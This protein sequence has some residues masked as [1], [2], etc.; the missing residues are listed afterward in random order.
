MKVAL[1]YSSK[2]GMASLWNRRRVEELREDEDEPPP[3]WFAECDAD[4][5]IQAVHKALAERYEVIP[6]ESDD[7]AY[8]RLK[9]TRPDLVFNIS[10]RLSGP[11]RESHIPTLCE[12]LEIPYTGSDPLTLGLCLD[13]SRA[14]EI[15]SYYNIPN[16]AFRIM[17]GGQFPVADDFP[18]PAIVKPLYE[19]SS[20]G[21][22]DNSVVKSAAEL[23]G[24]VGEI[25][26]VYQQPAIVERFLRGREFTAGVLGNSPNFEV[27]PIVEIDHS[28]LPCG[29]NPIYSYEAKWIWD[30]P[31]N[32][33][34]IFKCP[35]DL[36]AEL[37]ARMEEVITEACLVL[38]IKDW[39]RVDL[40]LDE[41]GEPNILELNPLPGIL[42]RP[43]DNSCLPK[44]ARAAGYSYSDLIH[45]VV[46]EACLRLGLNH[47]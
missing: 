40:R 8:D 32:P 11:N 30:R 29:A 13:K 20:K 37:R 17:D 42:P 1:I 19:G 39:C 26:S 34:A 25:F 28:M 24:R 9:D 41:R 12:I 10:E 14:K 6:I 3:D 27:L 23:R 46:D 7:R 18:L 2:T 44:A 38:R 4:E 15:L 22:R 5:T 33:L 21:I 31:E 47:E 43:E 35:A 45:R 36:S 16:P